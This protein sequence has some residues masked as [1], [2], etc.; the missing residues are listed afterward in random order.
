MPTHYKRKRAYGKRKSLRRKA[1]SYLSRKRTFRAMRKKKF[2]YSAPRLLAPQGMVPANALVNLDYW[3]QKEIPASTVAAGFWDPDSYIFRLNSAF[4]P[5]ATGAGHQPYFFDQWCMFFDRYKVVKCSWVVTG[6]TK[7]NGTDTA[8]YLTAVMYSNN[9]S[10]AAWDETVEALENKRVA[11]KKMMPRA[12][13]GG[14]APTVTLKGSVRPMQF[15]ANRDNYDGSANCSGSPPS[16]VQLGI[17]IANANGTVA[18]AITTTVISVRLR[19][20]I[21]FTERKIIGKS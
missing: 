4:A 16:L 10:V 18:S 9:E 12:Y 2:N 5:D 14:R 3:T 7:E 15:N 11:K 13:L 19:M 20:T 21:L 17:G 1:P 6:Y 8:K